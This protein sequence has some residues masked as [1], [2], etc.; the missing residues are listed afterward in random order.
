MG[1]RPLTQQ[2][3]IEKFR[4][5]R[6]DITRKDNALTEKNEKLKEKSKRIVELEQELASV[7]KRC[8]MLQKIAYTQWI[9]NYL[10]G[11]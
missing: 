3:L 7:K 9:T 11:E 6:E 2:Q 8:K 4:N 1:K 5:Q 10:E